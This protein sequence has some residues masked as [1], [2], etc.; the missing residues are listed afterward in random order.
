MPARTVAARKSRPFSSGIFRQIWVEWRFV[1]TELVQGKDG[2]FVAVEN[3]A[4]SKA[5]A[6]ARMRMFHV[7]RT[8]DGTIAFG[9]VYLDRKPA[10]EAVGLEE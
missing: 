1:S 9:S 3:Y 2:V 10:L 8:R 6:E 5:G 4:R 7:F